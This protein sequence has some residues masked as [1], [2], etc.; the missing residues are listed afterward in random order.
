M[1]IRGMNYK[2]YIRQSHIL[3]TIINIKIIAV[4]VV[5]NNQVIIRGK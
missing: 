5:V 1:N 3:K 2:K 4:V